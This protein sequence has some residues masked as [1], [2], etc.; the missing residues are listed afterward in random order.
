MYW[1]LG[2]TGGQVLF[3]RGARGAIHDVPVQRKPGHP[4]VEVGQ[5]AHQGDQV[6]HGGRRRQ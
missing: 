2:G 1:L 6:H 4:S 5:H 3:R